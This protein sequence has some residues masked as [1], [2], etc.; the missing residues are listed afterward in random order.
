MQIY[1]QEVTI[2]LSEG[3]MHKIIDYLLTSFKGIDAKFSPSNPLK[4]FYSVSRQISTLLY[5][6]FST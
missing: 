4:I 6:Y 2:L 5:V 1:K 3:G